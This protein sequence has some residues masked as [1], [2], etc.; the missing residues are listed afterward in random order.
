E[1]VAVCAADAALAVLNQAGVQP[2]IVNDIEELLADP[3]V[4]VVIVAS[5]LDERPAE[6]RRALQ[7]ERH[8]LCVHPADATPDT[9]YEAGMIQGDTGHILLPLLSGPSHPATR[10]LASWLREPGCPLGALR[11]LE[12]EWRIQ[13]PLLA[14]LGPKQNLVA[15]PGWDLLRTLVGEVAEISAFAGEEEIAPHEPVPLSGRSESGVL[16]RI[17][18]TPHEARAHIDLRCL[19]SDGRASLTFPD[20]WP[21]PATLRW[22]DAQGQAHEETWANVQP[23]DG[24]IAELEKR[25][26]EP[27]KPHVAGSPPPAEER[28][29]L[30]SWQTETRCLELDD[31]T[32]RSVERRRAILLE[33][34]EASEEVG[35]KG[36]MTLVGCVVLWGILGV[37]MISLWLPW[38]QW[39]IVPILLIFMGMQSFRWL[40]RREPP[41]NQQVP[42]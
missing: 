1:L 13:G 17:L 4:E 2:R 20:G 21:A 14:G 33:Y 16:F 41:P 23:W 24:V 8:V 40:A 11:L 29:R 5:S 31:A 15:L 28:S 12:I 26:G 37:F 35:F 34:P 3:A 32:R 27:L 9:A 19:G 7:S 36:T 38:L 10:R 39:T 42:S 6:L 25:A 30:L 18:F 22:S